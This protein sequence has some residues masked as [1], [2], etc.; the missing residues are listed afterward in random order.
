MFA[1]ADTDNQKSRL[2]VLFI[3]GLSGRQQLCLLGSSATGGSLV[4]NLGVAMTAPRV[5]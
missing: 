4:F 1:C 5:K 3:L 2:L